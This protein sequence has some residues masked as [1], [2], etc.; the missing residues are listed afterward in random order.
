MTKAVSRAQ[1][2]RNSGEAPREKLRPSVATTSR[3]AIT[4]SFHSSITLALPT[5]TEFLI[6][7]RNM[8]IR[9]L[10]AVW[11]AVL[12]CHP[13]LT[14]SQVSIRNLLILVKFALSREGRTLLGFVNSLRLRD[15]TNRKCPHHKLEMIVRDSSMFCV[16]LIYLSP[17]IQLENHCRIAP[18]SWPKMAMTKIN[19][20]HPKYALHPAGQLAENTRGRAREISALPLLS[21]ILG[22]LSTAGYE[23]I[24]M[25][26]AAVAAPCRSSFP[27]D[28]AYVR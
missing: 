22:R 21:G 13:Q 6:C 16:D 18:F 9:E 1:T 23:V 28:V 19:H 25:S 5:Y 8:L 7:C 17:R 11:V 26:G 12:L 27:R 20:F 24:G 2:E 14:E 15:N 10:A 4:R 3:A